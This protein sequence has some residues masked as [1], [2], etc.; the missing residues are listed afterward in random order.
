M[1]ALFTVIVAVPPSDVGVTVIVFPLT[2]T[3]AI[4]VLLDVALIAPPLVF[5]VTVN[6]P[7]V[8]YVYVPLVADK[9]NPPAA[10]FTVT[11]FV[12]VSVLYPAL[13]TLTDIVYDVTF[14]TVGTVVL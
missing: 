14:V 5:P 4:L 8:G 13:L 6:V 7:L 3:V 1:A 2:L 9:L 12:T 11:V 10:L